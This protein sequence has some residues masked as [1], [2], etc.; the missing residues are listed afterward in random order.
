VVRAAC[1]RE[2]WAAK[3]VPGCHVEGPYISPEDGPRGAHP[4]DHVRPCDPAELDRW[5]A[6]SGSRVRLVTLAPESAGAVEFIRYAVSQGVRI[7]IGHTAASTEQIAA[8]VDAGACLSTHLGNGA[9]GTLR[10]H[11]NY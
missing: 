2:P 11:P 9:H 7:S 6:A 3:M 8:A 4:L 1:E 10:R 5:Q